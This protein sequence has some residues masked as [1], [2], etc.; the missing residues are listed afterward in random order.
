MDR[1]EFFAK[2]VPF[3]A[4]KKYEVQTQSDYLS[5]FQSQEREVSWIVFVVLCCLGI[6]PGVI[7]YYV[8]CYKHS[9]TISISGKEEISIT[10]TGNT[11]KAKADAAEF[12]TLLR[13]PV[14]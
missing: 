14:S 13:P 10:A 9:V 6:L 11:D 7:Y 1:N 3:F 12:M 8:F 4:A 2:A 5:V